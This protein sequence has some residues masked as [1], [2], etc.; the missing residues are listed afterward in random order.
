MAKHILI[1]DD[2]AHILQV[3]SLK[4]RNA[5]YQ[6]TTAVDGEEGLE[7]VRAAVSA[8]KSQVRSQKS[9]PQIPIHRDLGTPALTSDQR[10]LT[11]DLRPLTS[12]VDLIITDF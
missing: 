9:G 11:S 1:I 6:V 5:G 2:E 10:P 3:L 12:G 7:I 8:Q 4:L